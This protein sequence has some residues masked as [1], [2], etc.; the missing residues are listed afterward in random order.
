MFYFKE[1]RGYLIGKNG[2]CGAA[3][4]ETALNLTYIL[5]A[6]FPPCTTEHLASAN[7]LPPP[8]KPRPPEIIANPALPFPNQSGP[9]D[10]ALSLSF[11]MNKS[12]SLCMTANHFKPL[13]PLFLSFCNVVKRKTSLKVMSTER[14][15]KGIRLWLGGEKSRCDITDWCLCIDNAH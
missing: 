12:M 11:P 8:L 9:K 1:R 15:V 2:W 3:Y 10:L 5:F 6:Q 14:T 4:R 13:K 7:S